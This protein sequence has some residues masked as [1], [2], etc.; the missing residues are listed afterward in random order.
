MAKIPDINWDAKPV[1]TFFIP[2]WGDKLYISDI[3]FVKHRS[4]TVDEF[5]LYYAFKVKINGSKEVRLH[6]RELQ[7]GK[8]ET[9]EHLCDYDIRDVT[10][11]LSK[12]LLLLYQPDNYF[13]YERLLPF[14]DLDED[15]SFEHA[16]LMLAEAYEMSN[17]I[18]YQQRV[19]RL[20]VVTNLS[21]SVDGQEE[22]VHCDNRYISQ[23][24]GGIQ[25]N[26]RTT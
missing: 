1:H 10:D 13:N 14:A 8:W 25:H 11:E 3:G 23:P 12:R 19:R 4:T 16:K 20:H 17:L 24:N 21:Y 22:R 5:V 9:D 6:L 7:L 18:S 26:G 2:M 15:A